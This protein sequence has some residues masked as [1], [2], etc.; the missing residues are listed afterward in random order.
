MFEANVIETDCKRL[1]PSAVSMVE[2]DVDEVALGC[3]G[4]YRT[5]IFLVA[6][7]VDLSLLLGHRRRLGLCAKCNEELL[8]SFVEAA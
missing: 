2:P 8:G 1:S 4:H 7:Y 6:F 3:E 5:A